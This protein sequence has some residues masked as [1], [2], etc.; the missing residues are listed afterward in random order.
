MYTYY[1]TRCCPTNTSYRGMMPPVQY[2]TQNKDDRFGG[3]LLPLLVG[4]AVGFPLG[5]ISSNTKNQGYG[6]P[7]YPQPYMQP[8]P[9]YQQYPMVPQQMPMY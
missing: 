9:M 4:A 1:G 2:R 3:L 5:Y 8:Y 7:M 6:Y